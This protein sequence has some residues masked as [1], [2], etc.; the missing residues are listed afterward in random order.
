MLACFI[1]CY[2]VVFIFKSL[3]SIGVEYGSHMSMGIHQASRQSKS[4]TIKMH[5]PS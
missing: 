2:F 3:K 4:Q 1:L 5:M